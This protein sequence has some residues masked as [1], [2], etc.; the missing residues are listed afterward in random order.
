MRMMRRVLSGALVMVV[1][2]AGS[3]KV[4]AQLQVQSCDQLGWTP[5]QLVNNILTGSG[6]NVTNVRFNGSSAVIHG[7]AIG[8]FSTGSTATNLGIREGIILSTGNVVDAVGPDHG[9]DYIQTSSTGVAAYND[10]QMAGLDDGGYGLYDCSVLEFDFIPR[11]DTVQFHFVFASE[12]YPSF[13]CNDYGDVFGFFLTSNDASDP[14]RYNNANIALVPGTTLPISIQTINGG[15]P[16]GFSS[17]VLTNTQYYV[18]NTDGA[19]I[20]FNGFTTVLTAKAHVTP[21]KSY[22]IKIGITDVADNTGNSAVFLEAGSLTS[23]QLDAP[24][25][26]NRLNESCCTDIVL[27]LSDPNSTLRTVA[28]TTS[29]SAVRGSDYTMPQQATFAAGVDSV[30]V[31][32]CALLDGTSEGT[33]SASI[34][35]SIVGSCPSIDADSIVINIVNVD[36]VS[37]SVSSVEDTAG[38]TATLTAAVTGGVPNPT[39]RWYD[40]IGS[41]GVV[42]SATKNV[43]LNPARRVAVCVVDSCGNQACDTITVGYY[44]CLSDA[45]GDTAIC[46]GES[47]T[48]SV[49]CAD[50]CVWYVGSLGGA[51]LPSRLPSVTVSPSVTTRYIVKAYK[52]V[53]GRWFEGT[54]TVEIGVHAMPHLTVGSNLVLYN[55][56]YNLCNEDSVRITW[57]GAEI[58][59]FYATNITG[60]TTIVSGGWDTVTG[61]TF[62]P[63]QATNY[64]S[65]GLSR[66][67]LIGHTTDHVCCD[68]V[69][70]N[71]LTS[72]RPQVTIAGNGHVCP[73]SSATLTVTGSTGGW[74]AYYFDWNGDTTMLVA[75]RSSITIP[76]TDSNYSYVV[77]AM[78]RPMTCVSSDTFHVVIHNPSF[79]LSADTTGIC[80]GNSVTITASSDSTL[81][82]QFW[83]YGSWAMTAS[84]SYTLATPGTQTITVY[85]RTRGTVCADTQTIDITVW[86][87]PTPTINPDSVAICNNER[88][89]LQATGLA[90]VS[91]YYRWS[92]GGA[93]MNSESQTP[94][95]TTAALTTPGQD[96][97]SYT[98]VLHSWDANHHCEGT[99]TA[100]VHV[101][102]IPDVTISAPRWACDSGMITIVASGATTYSFGDESHFDTVNIWQRQVTRTTT[103]TVYGRDRLGLCTGVDTFTV[104]VRTLPQVTINGR[105]SSTAYVCDR[106]SIVL[107]AGGATSYQWLDNMSSDAVRVER[108][109]TSNVIYTLSGSTTEHGIACPNT[110]TINVVVRT[111]SPA[112][113]T[114]SDT[115]ICDGETVTLT[116][117]NRDNVATIEY[118]W[119]D[120]LA[121]GSGVQRT[122]SPRNLAPVGTCHDTVYTYTVYSRNADGSCLNSATR[123]ITVHQLPTTTL[124]PDADATCSGGSVQFGYSANGCSPF[125]YSFNSTSSYGTSTQHTESGLT[126]SSARRYVLYVRDANGCEGSDTATIRVSNYPMGLRLSVDDSTVCAGDSVT[127]TA[128]GATQ[129][130]WDGGRTYG[131]TRVYGMVVTR[132]TLMTVY[133]ANDDTLCH[134]AA[135]VMVHVYTAPEL[136]A[137]VTDTVICNGGSSTITVSGSDQYRMGNSGSYGTTNSWTVS[138]TSTTTY[139]IFGR[140]QGAECPSNV[141]V[142]ITVKPLPT[143]VLNAQPDTVC[144]G[145]SATLRASGANLY[146]F[147]GSAPFTATDSSIVVPTRTGA[148]QYSVTGRDTTLGVTCTNSGNVTVQTLSYPNIRLGATD[149][150]FCKDSCVVLTARGA[151]RYSWMNNSSYRANN[152]RDT[153]CPTASGVYTV[154]GTWQNGMCES[155]QSINITVYMPTQVTLSSDRPSYGENEQAV[156]TATAAGCQFSWNGG[157]YGSSNTYTTPALDS[158]SHTFSVCAMNANGCVWCDTITVTAYAYAEARLIA[159]D[160]SI[161]RGESVTLTATGARYYSWDGGVNYAATPT[162]L[163]VVPTRDTTVILYGCDDL[164]HREYNTSDTVHIRVTAIPQFTLSPMSTTACRTE[165]VTYTA[166]PGTSGAAYQYSFNGGAFASINTHTLTADTTGTVRV[167]CRSVANN[168]CQTTRTATITVLDLPTVSLSATATDICNGQS[169]TLRARGALR[170]SWNGGAMTTDS[171]RTVNPTTTTVY[172]V[173]GEV[174]GAAVCR[175]VDSVTVRVHY[176]PVLTTSGDTAICIGDTI[177]LTASGAGLYEWNGGA[178]SRNGVYR[179]HPA[180][181]TRYTL[182]A[183]DSAGMCPVTTYFN[184]RVNLL[185]TVTLTSGA[186]RAGI[187]SPV[188]LTAAG[189][190]DYSWDFGSTYGSSTHIT[191]HG[192]PGEH[193]FCVIGRDTNGCKNVGCCR[194]TFFDVPSTLTVSVTS[195]TVCEGSSD[196]VLVQGASYYQWSTDG[197]NFA[198]STPSSTMTSYAIVVTQDT[199]VYVRGFNQTSDLSFYSSATARI[200]VKRYPVISITTSTANNEICFGDQTAIVLSGADRWKFDRFSESSVS[201]YPVQPTRTTRYAVEGRYNGSSCI[202]RDTV[203]IKVNM[204]P[205]VT[206]SITPDS[207]CVGDQVQLQATS[208]TARSYVWNDSVTGSQRRVSPAATTTYTVTVTDSN[209][210]KM[211]ASHQLRVF[212]YHP[213]TLAPSR[214]SFCHDSTITLTATSDAGAVY[215][216]LDDTIGWVR[217][218]SVRRTPGSSTNYYVETANSNGMC[219]SRAQTH[220][221]VNPL[222]YVRAQVNYS[223][224]C[225]GDRVRISAAGD[226]RWWSWNDTNHYAT[227]RTTLDTTPAG[228]S[229]HWAYFTIYGKTDSNCVSRHTDSVW[230]N[231][232]PVIQ[233]SGDTTVCQGDSTLFVASGAMQYSWFNRNNFGGTRDSM[234]VNDSI[235]KPINRDTTIVCYGANESSRCYSSATIHVSMFTYASLRARATTNEICEGDSVCITLSGAQSYSYDDPVRT[236]FNNVTTYCFAPIDTTTYRFYGLADNGR[237]VSDALV[238]INVTRLPRLYISTS[239]SDACVGDVFSARLSGADQYSWNGSYYRSNPQY[240]DTVTATRNTYYIGGRRLTNAGYCYSYDTV[241]IRRWTYPELRLTSTRDTICAGDSI[242]LTAQD[243]TGIRTYY[244]WQGDTMFRTVTTRDTALAL[245]GYVP[246]EAV[247]YADSLFMCVTHDSIYIHVN[248]LPYVHI[249]QGPE[250]AKCKFED[251]ELTVS[252]AGEGGEYSWFDTNDYSRYN[253]S[254]TDMPPATRT[255]IVYGRDDNY[256]V[257]WDTCRVVIYN[258]PD[259]F[260]LTASRYDIC[261]GDSVQLYSNGARFF[262][263]D[264]NG[265]W[266][267]SDSSYVTNLDTTSTL[268]MYGATDSTMCY[269]SAFVMIR[270]HEYPNTHATADRTIYCSGD[271][272]TITASGATMYA[273][274][275]GDSLFTHNNVFRVVV[276]ADTDIVVYGRDNI[277]LC[278]APDTVRVR[279]QQLPV[280]TVSASPDSIC[281]GSTSQLTASGADRYSWNGGQS[282]DSTAQHTVRPDST[283]VYVVWGESDYPANNISCRSKEEIEVVVFPYPQ[284]AIFTEVPSGCQG[285]PLRFAYSGNADSIAWLGDANYEYTTRSTDTVELRLDSTGWVYV[286]GK[287]TGGICPAKDSVY[288]TIYPAPTTTASITSDTVCAGD[289]VVLTLSGAEYYSVSN[290]AFG[291]NT[292]H[293]LIPDSTRTYIIVGENFSD[294]HR[295]RTNDTLTI[296]VMQY[297]DLHLMA[298]TLNICYGDVVTFEGGNADILSWEGGEWMEGQRFRTQETPL[299]THVY[300]LAGSNAGGKCVAKDS[301]KIVVHRLPLMVLHPDRP[302]ICRGDQVRLTVEDEGCVL[303]SWD[304]LATYTVNHFH[305]TT[306]RRGN[307]AYFRAYGVDAFGCIS[308]A[309]TVV[310]ISDVPQ[311][312]LVASDTAICMGDKIILSATGAKLYSW[313]DGNSYDKT[314]VITVVPP[315]DTVY[316]V[317]GAS[318]NE[319]CRSKAAVRVS[320]YE[321]PYATIEGP[322]KFCQGDTLSLY[323]NTNATSV[324]WSSEPGDRQLNYNNQYYNRTIRLKFMDTTTYTVEAYLH[325]C[326]TTVDHKVIMVPYPKLNISVN[327]REICVGGSTPSGVAIAPDTVIVEATGANLYSWDGGNTQVPDTSWKYIPTLPNPSEFYPDSVF[328]YWFYSYSD[329][330]LCRTADSVHV[331]VDQWPALTVC[332]GNNYQGIDCDSSC[333][334]RGRYLDGYTFA[335][336]TWTATPRD[337]SLEGQEHSY[338]PYVDPRGNTTYLVSTVNGKC[339]NAYTY[340]ISTGILPS[341]YGVCDPAQIRRGT[342]AVTYRNLS[343]N[344][345]G[346]MWYFP[347]GYYSNAK[348]RINYVVPTDAVDSFPVILIAYNGGC[349]DTSVV[350]VDIVNDEVWAPNA[351][352]PDEATN[353]IFY[354]RTVHATNFHMDIYSRNGILVFS[355]DDPEQG[356]D[357]KY[358]GKKC[359]QGTYVYVIKTEPDN[360]TGKD[361][362]VKGTVTLLR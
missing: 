312:Q 258:Y 279:V 40:P 5:E 34:Y 132:D 210:C 257:G 162:S 78:N 247:N 268:W 177:N 308:F 355:T 263:N 221:T 290:D 218:N 226:A 319:Q 93:W 11:S 353:S 309:D 117:S 230:V 143:V 45:G 305:D 275:E 292:T 284:V 8:T 141:T 293:I 265:Q 180:T 344:A 58:Y 37:V 69:Q 234:I 106:D 334:G 260:Y 107:R 163:T 109:L 288:I 227:R 86:P 19:T 155:S 101:H 70:M 85:G 23:Y 42:G 32:F 251:V 337:N 175:S 166:T 81:E 276:L 169:V 157:A 192:Q 271:T 79:S 348:D 310:T 301:V 187:G 359:P 350:R 320:V 6:V 206:M 361:H 18:D 190:S 259:N 145:S 240:Y 307:L 159:T 156:L 317:Y 91:H 161:C 125:T 52:L 94:G 149:T 228:N 122:V 183:T 88:A 129:Y 126:A 195:D 250:V 233:I 336:V 273:I 178:A 323:V 57:S 316:T 136:S 197:V 328:V 83:T 99:D 67:W 340:N 96:T 151:D 160:T 176:Q 171:V 241:S 322:D 167:I 224:I 199:T 1:F 170:Y 282:Y 256:C 357:G 7:N 321:Y 152:S 53:L 188:L 24:V 61:T 164:L 158:G 68:T 318:E 239:V 48:M 71:I 242:R 302:D 4:E 341:S 137:R 291:Y 264:A 189:A 120:T 77:R 343:T 134:R 211:S 60:T 327:T 286:Y 133:G 238:K 64:S 27:R 283:T 333:M 35:Y 245:S 352:T 324:F 236:H 315:H 248:T 131:S 28:F 294:G 9:A 332:N 298:D 277:N 303:Y 185:P 138:P 144:L 168:R 82:Y 182:R 269:D 73:N 229:G 72:K 270:V 127:F 314:N 262:T 285:E 196:T 26:A 249:T 146:S 231:S 208:A 139:S 331:R 297:P 212:N 274:E 66:F 14:V 43:A 115:S 29:G 74:G 84:R 39:I 104:H 59:R 114:A 92:R 165:Q 100:K 21:C 222:P 261:H 184:V 76:T 172:T 186:Q 102:P 209:G 246:I 203:T 330:T 98:Y 13:V 65:T 148:T 220:V 300:T 173:E 289:T 25:Y 47:Y 244:K 267:V 123:S 201:R 113:L 54:D 41:T 108:N 219:V 358:K 198:P 204:L 313:D 200:G 150:A 119:F 142:T 97:T 217:Y 202:S 50:S 213:V 2:L 243:T 345:A 360:H 89:T 3:T 295:C 356:W 326:T 62:L 216:W 266:I 280:F 17:C 36:P 51:T 16:N 225:H 31:P 207:M 140:P 306:P 56:N 20:E 281:I 237:C 12:E 304:S 105:T 253:T 46:A 111:P 124:T 55:D 252:G 15:V 335:P 44:S 90:G 205:T 116:A 215:R 342:N 272:A 339:Y 362:Y 351:F 346:V 121:F 174:S 296:T 278:V 194:V 118:S 33:E 49:A 193:E 147:T 135:Q 287:Y 347:D 254:M 130:S 38:G 179:V 80:A 154:F 63:I 354:V 153:I 112:R 329:D 214:R 181:T 128:T 191:T 87:I 255:Y 22:H 223:N 110:A 10:P 311:V 299:V 103:F 30:V 235:I 95:Y 349:F 325:I 232:V 338:R 75:N